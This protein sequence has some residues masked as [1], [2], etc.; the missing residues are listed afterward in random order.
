MTTLQRQGGDPDT[1]AGKIGIKYLPWPI[2]LF[3]VALIL[4][5][6]ASFY[7]GPLRLTPYRVVLLFA[8]IPCFMK[9]FSGK[10]GR[11]IATDKLLTYFSLWMILALSVKHGI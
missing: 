10:V 2:T 1:N 8:F 3:I 9:V 4:P 6:E 7:I 5:I 11:V